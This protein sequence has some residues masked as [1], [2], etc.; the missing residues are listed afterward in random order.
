ML[1]ESKRVKGTS[2][3]KHLKLRQGENEG[4]RES[5]RARQG[6]NREW[7]MDKEQ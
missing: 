5:E 2:D 6:G 4:E 1:V 7:F 3:R